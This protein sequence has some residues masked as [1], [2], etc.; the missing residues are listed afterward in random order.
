MK[1]WRISKIRK[2]RS[3]SK[4]SLRPSS[5]PHSAPST[6]TLIAPTFLIPSSRITSS[7]ETLE[8]ILK[9]SF[10][11]FIWY[12]WTRVLDLPEPTRVQ[13]DIA[14]WLAEGP[15]LR[16]TAAFR[17]VGKTFLTGAYIVW[18]LWRDPDLKIG[19]VSANERFAA[20]VAAFIH[21][22]INAEDIE[23]REPVPWAGLKARASQKN[24]TMQFDVGPAKPSKD[25]SVWAAG[26]GGQL[27]GGRSD[28]LL[29]DDVEVPN[30]SETEGQREKLVDRVGEAAAL[31]KP[32]GET[33]YLGTFQSMA[34]IYRGLK[35][36]GYAMRLWPSRYPLRAKMELYEADLAPILKADLEERPELAEP[37]YGSSLG[38]A[39]TDP[40]RFNEEDLIERETEWGVAPFQLQFMLDTSL[41]DQE[42]FPLK[43]RDLIVTDVDPKIAPIHL[44]WSSAGKQMLRDLDN[45]GFDGDRFYGPLYV[46]DEWKP[47]SG[48]ILE[49]DP[50]G[51]G[52]DETAYALTSFLNGRIYLRKWGGFKD[53]HSETTMA[54]LAAIAVEAGVPLIRVEANF[55]DGMFSRLLETH[56]R[57]AGFKGRVEDHKVTGMK[58]ARIVQTLHPVIQNHRLVV[59]R[60]VIEDD[61]AEVRGSAERKWGKFAYLEFSGL[62]QL[63]HMANQRGALRKDDRV[64]VLTNAVAY[65]LDYMALDSSIAEAAELRKDNQE[66]ARLV[67]ATQLKGSKFVPDP[68][69]PPPRS[70]QGFHQRAHAGQ[71]P[72][73]VQASRAR[74]G[75]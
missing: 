52:T 43:T 63:T 57:Q 75:A 54:A 49:I 15:R 64:D 68:I 55:G 27:T 39:P 5:T 70:R 69:H 25:P 17:G 9:G 30:N 7:P 41:T 19:V 23:T 65:W 38:G 33:I 8:S 32:E 48:T 71:H 59:D 16:F 4:V 45:V 42:K 31:R 73:G 2:G 3:R 44:S 47:Y 61:L 13:Y 10:L 12:V 72:A 74:H 36:K 62:Y 24:S 22:L 1:L 66:F 18:R 67:M 60:A 20:T 21:T 6:S 14:R 56:L 35:A 11:K 50:S 40:A 29:F 26:I 46:A 28:I 37:R 34:S 58:E 53:G 51:S